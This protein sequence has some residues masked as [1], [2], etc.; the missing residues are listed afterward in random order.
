[1]RA[2]A[3]LAA[4]EVNRNLEI[5]RAVE[6]KRARIGT[7]IE[8]GQFSMVYQPIW[9]MR[10]RLAVGFECLARFSAE[11]RRQPNEWFGEAAEVGLGAALELAAIR[12]ASA[13]SHY[14]RRRCT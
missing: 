1:V 11:P 5:L 10:S 7:V 3:D 14:C 8:S 9:N 12:A 13:G 4:F 2:F 6:E